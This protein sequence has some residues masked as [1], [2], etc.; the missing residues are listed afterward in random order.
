MMHPYREAVKKAYD[1]W[2]N[3]H[4]NRTEE[5]EVTAFRE[6]ADKFVEDYPLSFI[7]MILRGK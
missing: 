5:E 4:P 7:L 6:I 2:C 3:S 1:E